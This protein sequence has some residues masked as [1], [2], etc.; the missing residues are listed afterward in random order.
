V[1][2]ALAAEAEQE[3]IEA[4][5]FMFAKPTPNLATHSSLSLSGPQCCF[6][7]NLTW[8]QFGA[9]AFGGFRCGGFRT[10]SSTTC[11]SPRSVYSSLLIRGASQRSGAGERSYLRFATHAA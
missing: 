3:L 2:L 6:S 1:R 11:A 9:A 4:P 5:G 10:A 8:V 7:N